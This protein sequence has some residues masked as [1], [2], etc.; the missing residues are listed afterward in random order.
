ME[1][2]AL[3]LSE[4]GVVMNSTGTDV[5]HDVVSPIEIRPPD[6][7]PP[8]PELP[9]RRGWFGKTLKVTLGTVA[10]V[11]LMTFVV[12]TTG[13][14][15]W[16]LLALV[17]LGS[18][19]VGVAV[20]VLA[21]V[22]AITMV[23]YWLVTRYVTPKH[24]V[25]R[26]IGATTAV[27]LFAGGIWA[28]SSPDRSLFM[29]RTM[30]WGDSDVLDWVKFDARSIENAPPVF[31]FTEAPSPEL[32]Q[33]I[34][35]QVEG[36]TR[37]ADFDAFLQS[38]N[39]TSFIVIKDDAILY[40]GYFNGYERDSIVTSFST[41]KSVTSALIGIAIDEGSI[42]SVNDPMVSY[43]P[44]M[45]G[46][47]LDD[48]TIRDLL[49]MSTGVRFLYA[50][51]LPAPATMWPY[52]DDSLSYMYPNLRDLALGLP[53]SDEPAG[54]AFK[55]NPYNTIL[56]GMILERATRT[57][58]TQYLQEE[59]WEPL[60]MEFP[61]TWSLD[62]EEHGFPK[63]ESGLNGRAIDFAKFGRLFLNNGNW[64][65]DQIVSEEWVTESTA[66]DPTDD[67]PWLSDQEWNEE[68]GY[69][70]YQ[71]WGMPESDGGYH[72]SAFGHLGQ[73]IAVFPEENVIIVRYGIN[74]EGV[75]SWDEV[76]ATVAAM[77]SPS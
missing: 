23:M 9:R 35:Y 46:R 72:Y 37:T 26:I 7:E 47:G 48:V 24:T 3:N 55:Y 71:W 25:R 2:A 52:Q 53:P 28:V 75:D 76:I 57:P 22:G 66:P 32:F 74:D 69:Y 61:A 15:F 58:V 38:T 1:A 18:D 10:W 43:L 20:V 54:A 14:V 56:L 73:R 12:A 50:D 5:K 29:A 34:E 8:A 67:R 27:L 42:G 68:G 59:I 39:T 45:E 40:E 65:G 36:Q 77:A 63:M 51:D 13:V 30:A 31:N 16:M 11:L 70:K 44:E 6:E 64:N 21:V 49:L 19:P 17:I 4:G 62:S 60:G 33:T 41:A